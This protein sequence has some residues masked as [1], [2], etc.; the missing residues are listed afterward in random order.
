[1]WHFTTAAGGFLKSRS[2]CSRIALAL[3][4]FSRLCRNFGGA[5]AGGASSM[6][7][8][9]LSSLPGHSAMIDRKTNARRKC[10]IK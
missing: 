2:P 3:G 7:M 9:L 10:A 6:S 5:A 8:T 1:M 4:G